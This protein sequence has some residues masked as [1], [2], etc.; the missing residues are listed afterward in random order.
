[1]PAQARKPWMSEDCKTI[2]FDAAA[3]ALAFFRFS[4]Q[5]Q[6]EAEGAADAA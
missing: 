4:T 3:L 6:C 1:L 5:Q 2:I